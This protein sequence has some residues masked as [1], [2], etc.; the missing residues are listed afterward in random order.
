M[1]EPEEQQ[2]VTEME[3]ISKNIDRILNKIAHLD[4]RNVED[5]SQ[6]DES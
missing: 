1:L 4:P 6:P 2:I 5:S 3:D